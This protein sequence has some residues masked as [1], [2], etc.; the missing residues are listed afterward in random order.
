MKKYQT[1]KEARAGNIRNTNLIVLFSIKSILIFGLFLLSFSARCTDSLWVS[2]DQFFIDQNKSLALTNLNVSNLNDTSSDLWSHI[3]L[4]QWYQFETPVD[5]LKY[6]VAYP[7]SATE[8]DA[9]LILY[10]TELP[11]VS[12]ESNDTILDD[13]DVYARFQLNEM[14]KTPKISGM[15][16]QHRGSFS[17]SYP[18][19]SMS[20]EFWQDSTG[21]STQ[22]II[23]LDMISD[24][25]WNLQAMYNEPLRIR[26]KTN[27]DLWRLINTLHY[28]DLEPNA[29][30][31]VRMRYVELFINNQY[32]GV[33]CIGEK[34][35][36]KQL[37]LKKHD[38]QIRGALYKGVAWGAT[39]FNSAPAFNNTSD[40]WGGFEYKHP[41]EEIDWSALH[42]FVQF[43]MQSS[44]A[45]FYSQIYDRIEVD[46]L[47][48]YF[49]FLNLLRATDNFGKNIYL[50]R[51]DSDSKFFYVPWDLDGAFGTI[52]TGEFENI[53]ND[54][55]SN[56]LFNR[57][58]KD[59]A[60]GGFREK[61]S[62]KWNALRQDIVTHENLMALFKENHDYLMQNSVYQREAIAWSDFEYDPLA[63]NQM[64]NWI[65]SRL[66]YLDQQFGDHC[67][68]LS[69]AH[70]AMPDNLIVFPNPTDDFLEV[71]GSSHQTI[72]RIE[73]LNLNGQVIDEI[74]GNENNRISSAFL[75]S[76]AY[77]LRVYQIE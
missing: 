45:T 63:L 58:I 24:D 21:T 72:N 71:W 66:Q 57:L 52:Y 60:S 50:A 41:K 9:V 8:S 75:S 42:D 62:Q 10:F 29:I 26:S 5:T 12:I 74:Q 2:V 68:T 7:I 30:N 36:R 35:K 19:K 16:I 31:G 1:V 70:H 77:T 54:L 6:G 46:N 13:E 17:L 39:T 27:F 76:G 48:D 61:L 55:L 25:D 67:L 47:V 28:Q 23:I 40:N 15:G 4:G 51:Y 37:R 49:I 59:C 14:D 43:V 18:K 56:G 32:R 73:I 33:Y 65:S 44:D 20:I 53:Y 11:I 38:G 3:L 64:E 22:N 34:V 69:I